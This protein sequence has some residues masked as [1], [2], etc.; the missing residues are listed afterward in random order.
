V[1][2]GHT[3][4]EVV[5]RPTATSFG[6]QLNPGGALRGGEVLQRVGSRNRRGPLAESVEDESELM[7]HAEAPV[8]LR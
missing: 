1:H 2:G 3:T 8:E 4:E 7:G 5:L 6:G